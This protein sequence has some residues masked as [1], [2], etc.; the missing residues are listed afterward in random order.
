MLLKNIINEIHQTAEAPTTSLFIS[1]FYLDEEV[2]QAEL[3]RALAEDSLTWLSGLMAL[4]AKFFIVT[5][6]NISIIVRKYLQSSS[7]IYFINNTSIGQQ[8]SSIYKVGQNYHN[9]KL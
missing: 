8:I 3:R 4:V 1:N 9:F 7:E 2:A 6:K 5:A